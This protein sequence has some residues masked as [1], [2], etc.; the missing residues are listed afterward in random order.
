MNLIN[1]SNAAEFLA[2]ARDALEANEA[3]NNLMYGLAL[4]LDAS[5]RAHP[6]PTLLRRG[7]GRRRAARG[8][9]YDPAV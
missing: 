5:P 4:R 7:A 9:D 6:D 3:A 2:I 8:G 1:C